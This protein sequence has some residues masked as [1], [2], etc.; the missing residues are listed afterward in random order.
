MEHFSA[1]PQA[2]INSTKISNQ[3][4]AVFQYFLS[5]DIKKVPI[6]LHTESVWLHCL[7]KKV[8]TS[9]LST[10]WENPDGYSEQYICASAL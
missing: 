7:K 2:G 10:I 5:D 9:S 4:H 6:V 8:L 3:R 1:L